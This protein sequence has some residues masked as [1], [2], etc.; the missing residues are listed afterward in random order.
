MQIIDILDKKFE[1]DCLSCDF[2]R[3][4]AKPPFGIIA[5]SEYFYANHDCEIPI[6]GFLIVSS[7]RHVKSID[8][9]TKDERYD[10]I[11]FVSRIRSAMRD[12]LAIEEVKLIQSEN[13][14]YH[15][16]LWLFPLWPELAMKFGKG[17]RSVQLMVDYAL[18]KWKTREKIDLIEN[19]VEQLKNYLEN[20]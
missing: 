18:E 11:D 16:H 5:K 19:Y 6:P 3:G 4:K 15:F 12:L 8:E 9:F 2:W 7:K 13:S 20:E 17:T 1:T 10:F 14:E